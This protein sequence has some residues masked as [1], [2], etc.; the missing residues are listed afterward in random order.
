MLIQ[1]GISPEQV[2]TMFPAIFPELGYEDH[3]SHWAEMGVDFSLSRGV[4]WN[5]KLVG[6]ALLV[7]RGDQAF[8][9]S[10]GVLPEA[11]SQGAAG[12]LLTSLLKEPLR[13]NQLR[14]E[15]NSTNQKAF[16]LYTRHGF[17][18]T[19]RLQSFRGVLK[20]SVKG[21]DVVVSP[22]RHQLMSGS[23]LSFHQEH[24]VPGA[25]LY[26]WKD[27]ARA[28]YHPEKKHLIQLEAQNTEAA[29]TLL[30]KMGIDEFGVNSLDEDHPLTPLWSELGCL[31]TAM[32]FE[33]RKIL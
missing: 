9:L 15:I 32:Y 14:L 25:Y 20:N 27:V 4:I 10:L 28:L 11:R 1:L 17:R 3:L 18:I 29:K 6:F 2:L 30:S 13:F 16:V 24:P 31:R 26:E 23:P 7:P 19:R 21:N 33:M 5:E 8:L 22:W 12:F